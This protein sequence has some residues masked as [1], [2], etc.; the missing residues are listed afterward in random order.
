MAGESDSRTADIGTPVF[1]L[2]AVVIL[3][4][5]ALTWW[6]LSQAGT[7][8]PKWSRLVY[9]YAGVE[10][11]V[12]AASGAIFGTTVQRSHVE[13]AEKREYQARK[14]AASSAMDAELGRT[15]DSALRAEVGRAPPAAPPPARTDRIGGP[16]GDRSEDVTD[17]ISRLI[18][19]ADEV[20]TR[21]GR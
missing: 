19:L 8:D 9:V 1:W 17:T 10:A 4:F 5:G 16:S 18:R 3:A 15:L 6:L 14:E 21:Q 11:I 12:F 7:G 2:G 20:R 13:A